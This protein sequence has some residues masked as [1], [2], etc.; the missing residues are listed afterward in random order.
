[1]K[2]TDALLAEHTVFHHI[3]DHLEAAVP[4]ARTLAEVR[5]LAR[6]LEALLAD[7]SHTEE[8]LLMTPLDH[9]LEQI[10]QRDLFHEEHE[11]IERNL[12]QALKVRDVRTARRTLLVAVVASR[13]HFD[14]EE[15]VIFPLANRVLKTRT[16]NELGDTWIA[17]RNKLKKRS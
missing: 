5:V 15:R 2:I 13:R 12:G 8:D 10:G 3:F 14:K 1:M 9:C 7:H 11:G 16:L 17:L 6:L 4:R